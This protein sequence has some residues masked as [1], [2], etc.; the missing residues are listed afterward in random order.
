MPRT[1]IQQYASSIV[2]GLMGKIV[3]LR[4]LNHKLT[5]GELRELFISEILRAF[6]TKQFDVGSGVVIN[7]KG[8][9]SNQIDIII[10]DNRILPPFIREQHLGIYPAESV[11][12][13]IEVKSNLTKYEILKAEKSASKLKNEIYSPES[14]IYSDF[15]EFR[16]TCAVIGFYGRGVKA[17]ANNITGRT[18][19]KGNINNLSYLCLVNKYS[20]INMLETGWTS[21]MY[22]NNLRSNNETKRFIA[23]LLDN[24][25]TQ[26]EKRLSLM[27]EE[28]KDWLGAYLR[29][30]D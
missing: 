24:I 29:D 22:D 19:I 10:Y 18:W 1:L 2:S 5:K 16:P 21:E 27:R 8:F 26:S 9:Q 15:K 30:W 17:L 13:T 7:Q 3:S 12:A 25:R 6:L 14:S 28:H 23:V 11:L 20:W 4:D